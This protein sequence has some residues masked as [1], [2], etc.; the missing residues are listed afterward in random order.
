MGWKFWD[1]VQNKWNNVADDDPIHGAGVSGGEYTGQA[2]WNWRGKNL[3]GQKYRYEGSQIEVPTDKYPKSYSGPQPWLKDY[4]EGLK[5]RFGSSFFDAVNRAV[6]RLQGASPY[7]SETKTASGQMMDALE[8][9]KN[10]PDWIEQQRQIMPK[11]FLEAQPAFERTLQPVL[12]SYNA[13]GILDSGVTGGALA[14]V[15]SE[16]NRRYNQAIQ[17]ANL[18]ANQMNLDV[19]MN[20][21]QIAGNVTNVL[22]NLDRYWLAK[23]AAAGQLG[24]AGQSAL[25]QLL[26]IGG[27]YSESSNEW[28]P[29]ATTLPYALQQA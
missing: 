16:R 5:N 7:Q 20:H 3:E 28:A 23:E 26:G 25:N 1:P 10:A 21:P 6:Q 15:I 11:L 12:D 9:L 2:G 22:N 14:A 4:A 24:T 29:W 8:N 27:T 19:M 17:E 18:T 13:R